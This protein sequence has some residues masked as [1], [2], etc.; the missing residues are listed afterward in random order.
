[1]IKTTPMVIGLTSP[2]WN[3][4][5]ELNIAGTGGSITNMMAMFSARNKVQPE[6][7][8]MGND[9]KLKLRAFISE[10]AHYSF[11]TAA[12]LLGIGTNNVI[13]VKAD[14]NG[15]LIPSELKKNKPIRPEPT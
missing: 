11:E 5:F 14:E 10:H 1:M 4:S 8:L 2:A 15:R 7:H 12:N 6:S 13:K 3:K 9:R